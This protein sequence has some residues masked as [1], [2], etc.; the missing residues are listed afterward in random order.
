MVYARTR[1]GAFITVLIVYLLAFLGFWLV[2]RWT[3]QGNLLLSSFYG[4]IAATLIVWLI[5]VV[6]KN[7]SLYDP[8][9]SV[10]PLF[11][12]SFWLLSRQGALDVADTLLLVA[13][14]FW[15]IRLTLNWAVRWSGIGHQD[16]RY[17]QLKEQHPRWWFLINLGGINLMPTLVVFAGMA[18]V[19][20]ALYH[21]ADGYNFMLW[22]GFAACIAAATL[23]LVADKQ[24]DQFKK[25]AKSEGTEYIDEGVWRYSRH[26]NYFGEILFWWGLWIMQ[27]GLNAAIWYTVAG[28]VLMTLLFAVVSIPLMER[29]IL[30]SKPGY[31]RY[32]KTVS[33]LVP[34]FRKLT[35]CPNSATKQQ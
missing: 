3:F 29:H 26:P 30:A 35:N 33:V 8:Y 2:H 23:Q 22:L 25:R 12:L 14:F 28:P 27:M 18:P 6:Y 20:V 7:S 11:L 1:L 13:V 5:G 24:M 19:Y 4:D 17:T 16:W 32:Q 31:W 10:T 9:W 34:W 15:G 21:R